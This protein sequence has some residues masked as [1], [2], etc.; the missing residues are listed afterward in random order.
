MR[1]V[2]HTMRIVQRLRMNALSFNISGF[3][4]Y[5]GHLIR[6]SSLRSHKRRF[7]VNESNFTLNDNSSALSENAVSLNR[8]SF[9]LNEN[10]FIFSENS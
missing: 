7:I 9:T 5:G 8:S 4:L 2:L 1:V 6:L 10:S 3:V